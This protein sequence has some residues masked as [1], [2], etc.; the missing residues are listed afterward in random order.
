MSN[1]C[2]DNTDSYFDKNRAKNDFKRYRRKGPTGTT[3]VLLKALSRQNLD[4][5]TL[6]DVGGGIGIIGFELLK[7][8]IANAE[9][10]EM[11]SGAIAIS[12]EEV[13]RLGYEDQFSFIHGDAVEELDKAED[14]S[15]ITLDRVVCCYPDA[16]QL[17][18]KLL[19]KARTW[20]AISYPRSHW[21]TRLAFKLENAQRKRAGKAFRTYVHPEESIRSQIIQAGFDCRFFKKSLLWN[22]EVYTRT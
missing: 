13:T 1:C 10:I 16:E 7:K 2:V 5:A 18:S 21:Y 19:P 20:F 9:S 11:S 12:Q 6:L 14:S 22:V 4:K 8:G 15:I 17:L 3:R